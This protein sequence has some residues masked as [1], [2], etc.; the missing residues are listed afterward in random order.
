MDK[1][2]IFL[3]FFIFLIII[4]S[5]YFSIDETLITTQ[6]PAE[7]KDQA[8][9]QLEEVNFSVYSQSGSYEVK[10]ESEKVDNYQS[11]AKMHLKPIYG[12]VY[13]TKTGKLLYTLEGDFARYY[14]KNEYLEVRGN[15]V[16]DSERYH[17]VSEELDYQLNQNY[18]EGRGSA[19][20][21]GRDFISQAERFES[22][23]NLK[24]LQLF[25]NEAGSRPAE[26][27]F[28]QLIEE[29]DNE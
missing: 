12:E 8:E 25:K 21:T 28:K 26:I 6:P 24:D 16:I 19:V 20:I 27:K 3:A 14:T 9:D 13:S 7:K 5:F 11:E 22:N 1:K 2:S 4:L 10:I 29:S 17:I 15:V 18:L 23:L